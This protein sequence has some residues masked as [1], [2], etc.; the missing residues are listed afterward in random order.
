MIQGK[1]KLHHEESYEMFVATPV[2]NSTQSQTGYLSKRSFP[3]FVEAIQ[4]SPI[5]FNIQR[6]STE[7]DF[8]AVINYK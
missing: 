2:H 8:I 6:L 7:N 1:I 4:G 5:L 3:P